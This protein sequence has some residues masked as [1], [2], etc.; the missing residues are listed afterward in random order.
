MKCNNLFELMYVDDIV[1]FFD[2]VEDRK[3]FFYIENIVSNCLK[4]NYLI[5]L[6]IYCICI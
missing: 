5:Y 3:C 4:D 1:F 2:F 6:K